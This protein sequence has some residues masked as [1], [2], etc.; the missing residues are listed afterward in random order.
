MILRND[1]KLSFYKLISIITVMF[2]SCETSLIES[3]KE[4][5]SKIEFSK[6]SINNVSYRSAL[7][8]TEITET[9]GLQ[10]E[11]HGHCWSINENPNLNDSISE[12]GVLTS[13]SYQ[14]NLSNLK[15]NTTYYIKAYV[16]F[17]DI[18]LYSESQS[19]LTT[20]EVGFPIIATN[21]ILN[22][23]AFT[24]ETG[25]EI[26]EN[27]GGVIITKGICWNKISN[28]TI[29]DNYFAVESNSESFKY[30]LSNLEYGQKYFVKAYA[31]NEKGVSYGNE[32]VFRT[33][34]LASV[35]VID[36]SNITIN[37]ATVSGSISYDGGA[38][39]T[40]RGICYNNTGIP[41]IDDSIFYSG[42]GTGS[43]T[44]D[45]E[46]LYIDSMYYMRSFAI[47]EAGISYSDERSFR[48]KNGI[49][50]ISTSEVLIIDQSTAQSGGIITDD[51][52]LPVLEKGV[53]WSLSPNPTLIDWKTNDG[54]GAGTFSSQL[55]NLVGD[56]TYYVRAYAINDVD[57]FYGNELSFV[58]SFE[59]YIAYYT[60]DGNTN[61]YSGNENHA[62]NYGATLTTDRFGVVNSA[63]SFDGSNDYMRIDHTESLNFDSYLN[64]YTLSFWVK[65]NSA[66]FVPCRIIEKWNEL[67]QTPY[68]YS[69]GA[70]SER[71]TVNIR[72]NDDSKTLE[73]GNIWNEI[74]Q[75][76]V[77]VVNSENKL[78]YCYINNVMI[79]NTS[80]SS[81]GATGN[82]EG[83]Y[84]GGHP[85]LGDRYFKG[86]M[87]DVRFYNRT[88]TEDEIQVLYH[89]GGWDL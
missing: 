45:L 42:N 81:L 55:I 11:Q 80:Y 13:K 20:V 10:I 83:I 3:P 51:G 25:G 76:V 31:T 69:I 63:Y 62:I 16:K 60:F 67:I 34:T 19:T 18:I 49:P 56:S 74:W 87:D 66:E 54:S 1:F 61:D 85:A 43:F 7:I 50:V 84:L 30:N 17:G 38:I 5:S 68:P 86:Y 78:M 71:F 23:T 39:V 14:S 28:P 57:T 58:F 21:D 73:Y 88:L 8:L 40:S 47:N 75:H 36:V 53:C 82:S 70:T 22:I 41:S 59:T 48:T 89:E 12:L 65:G 35:S 2:V 33:D 27:N 52:G 29:E 24:A 32:R 37:S 9:Y 6:I 79:A 4:L 44:I 72:N 46:N 15:P 77:L 26:I 64:S